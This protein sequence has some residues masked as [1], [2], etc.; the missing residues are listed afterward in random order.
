MNKH[1]RFSNIILIAFLLSLVPSFADAVPGGPFFTA[2]HRALTRRSLSNSQAQMVVLSSMGS[3]VA[4][5]I[6]G[7]ISSIRSMEKLQIAASKAIK[8]HDNDFVREN[9]SRFLVST[10]ETLL[11]SALQS[12]NY[13]AMRIILESGVSADLFRKEGVHAGF[14]PLLVALVLDDFEGAHL[15]L[16]YKANPAVKNIR[17]VSALDYAYKN[18]ELAKRMRTRVEE[19]EK[20]RLSTLGKWH[21]KLVPN[22]EAKKPSLITRIKQKLFSRSAKKEGVA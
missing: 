16:D 18:E 13:E 5:S 15:L 17:G 21:C 1:T 2:W 22:T 10:K 19:I 11:W 9:V 4:G 6:V 20:E 8:E 12:K 7:F 3:F 14:T